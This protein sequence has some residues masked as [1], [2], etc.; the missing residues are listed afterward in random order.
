M[1][2]IGQSSSAEVNT[3]GILDWEAHYQLTRWHFAA[4]YLLPIFAPSAS[5]PSESVI[6]ANQNKKEG[7][8]LWDDFLSNQKS[9][10]LIQQYL[11]AEVY[12]CRLIRDPFRHCFALFEEMWAVTMASPCC[13]GIQQQETEAETPSPHI[14]NLRGQK[15]NFL[16]FPGICISQC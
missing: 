16:S 9:T 6:V 3:V 14:S 7:F 1:Q 10:P 5:P 2:S 12:W 13:G 8:L 15:D 4:Q 11:S